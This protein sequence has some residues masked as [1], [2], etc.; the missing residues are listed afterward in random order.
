MKHAMHSPM[1]VIAIIAMTL[2]FSASQASERDHGDTQ[3][4]FTA[5]HHHKDLRGEDVAKGVV[6][7][8]VATCGI[9]LAVVRINDS[10]WTWCGG[11]DQRAAREADDF[12]I[13]IEMVDVVNRLRIDHQLSR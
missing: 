13:K 5:S 11:A 7:G 10:R 2:V 4:P 12:A 9:R 6:L 8:F 1:V 3:N